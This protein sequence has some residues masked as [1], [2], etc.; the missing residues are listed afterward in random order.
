MVGLD[1]RRCCGSTGLYIYKGLDFTRC[2]VRPLHNNRYLWLFQ[3]EE[4]DEKEAD[5]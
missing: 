1:W 5:L 2:I 3:M 4:A